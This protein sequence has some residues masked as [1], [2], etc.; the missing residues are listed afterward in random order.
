M[1]PV[2]LLQPQ[3][4]SLIEIGTVLQRANRTCLDS[5][6]IRQRNPLRLSSSQGWKC[7]IFRKKQIAI[8]TW[9]IALATFCRPN[10]WNEKTRPKLGPIGKLKNTIKGP[11]QFGRQ[12]CRI[13][14]G[15]LFSTKVLWGVGLWLGNAGRGL[16]EIG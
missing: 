1:S 4:T 16:Q 10:S 3:L 11:R 7:V 12:Y 15:L 14:V 13:G 6:L 2:V 9:Q 8:S 5:Q